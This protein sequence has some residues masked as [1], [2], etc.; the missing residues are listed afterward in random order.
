M[1][2]GAERARAPVRVAGSVDSVVP[3]LVWPAL[4][5]PEIMAALALHEQFQNSEWWSAERLAAMQF[6]QLAVLLGHAKRTV[7]H[8]RKLLP[9][10]GRVG[11]SMLRALPILTRAEAQA[12]PAALVSHAIPPPHLP[13]RAVRS[14]GSTGRPVEFKTTSVTRLFRRA[15]YLREHR[16]HGRD[17]TLTA[18]TIRN[19]RDGSGMPP[20]GKRASNWGSGYATKPI[21]TLNI[22]ATVDEQLEWL[23][24][25]KPAYLSTFP[26]NLRALAQ[27]A[28]ERGVRLHRMRQVATYAESLPPGLRE[29]ARQAFGATVTDIYSSEETGPIAYQCPKHE[30]RYHVQ[31]ENLIVE[32]VD[33]AGQPCAPG[34]AGR[35]LVTDLHNLATPLIRY[36]IGDF[37]ATGPACDCGRGLPVLARI[38]GRTRNMLRMPGGRTRW[39]SLPSGDELG[40]IAP[41]RQFQLLQKDLQRLE[42]VLVV[43]R[44]LSAKEEARVRAAFLADLGGGFELAVSYAEAI[45]RTPGGKYE[46][47][48]CEMPP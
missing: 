19:F 48:R 27:S 2:S 20:E 16:W 25:V 28:L 42:L 44:A 5:R 8:Y 3:G 35:V 14:S 6:H 39:P 47:F 7:P 18:A 21:E 38:L 23:Q 30:D 11:T 10:S 24:R 29:L 32:V 40:R 4:P 41:V 34:A 46:D 22:R 31:S 13:L 45:A 12:D 15:L 37:A 1:P 17:L 26:T 36:E 43:A 33:D 9:A